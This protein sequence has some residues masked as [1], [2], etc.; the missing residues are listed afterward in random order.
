M[1][2]ITP[3]YLGGKIGIQH[4]LNNYYE[5]Q[6]QSI[7][8]VQQKLIAR[9]VIEE[10]LIVGGVRVSLA[11]AIVKRNYRVSDELLSQ[12]L[13]TRLIRIENTHLGRAFEVSHDTL[14][15]PILESFSKRF[16]K[17]QAIKLQEEL[18]R[19]QAAELKKLAEENK[20]LKLVRMRQH[21]AGGIVTFALLV[22]ILILL[23]LSFSNQGRHLELTERELTSGVYEKKYFNALR[24]HLVENKYQEALDAYH[25]TIA[26][27][28]EGYSTENLDTF[29]YGVETNGQ[30][31]VFYYKLRF[32]ITPSIDSLSQPIQ[33]Y[34]TAC[35]AKLTQKNKAQKLQSY[36]YYFIESG[37]LDSAILIGKQA[38]DVQ[39]SMSEVWEMVSSHD[40]LFRQWLI[41]HPDEVLYQEIFQIHFKLLQFYQK[42]HIWMWLAEYSKIGYQT[43][44]PKRLERYHHQLQELYHILQ[45]YEPLIAPNLPED[46]PY[47]KRWMTHLDRFEKGVIFE[48][49]A[50][51]KGY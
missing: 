11:E 43:N 45:Y 37:Q 40:N 1:L 2:Q 13:K 7:E 22:C 25:E 24:L 23:F 5:E 3:A 21:I 51:I 32:G 30:G 31:N 6:I 8:D 46:W 41:Q 4:I 20:D 48:E 14:V 33:D 50:F 15:E 18:E 36:Y 34:I 49:P 47:C 38:I 12:L 29:N 16:E 26:H 17:E 9:Q 44:R 27:V 39:Y 10:G 28:L 19:Q 35:K 42:Q